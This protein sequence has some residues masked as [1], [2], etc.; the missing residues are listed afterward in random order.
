MLT[1]D[2]AHKRL[3]IVLRTY[4]ALCSFA[5]AADAEDYPVRNCPVPLLNIVAEVP[6]K[7]AAAG[8]EEEPPP[9]GIQL[10]QAGLDYLSGLRPPL[11]MVPALGVYRGGKSMLLNRLQKKTAPYDDGFGVGHQ[12]ETYTRGIQICHEY[13]ADLGTI[14]W[15]DTEG[16]F[17]AEDARGAYGPK[18]FSLALLFSSAVILNNVKVLEDKFFGFFA[19]QQ[20][21]ARM[22]RQGLATEGLPLDAL[23]PTSLSIF[24]VLQQPIH[25]DATGASE[26]L[27][28]Q[29]NTFLDKK[30]DET[31][32]GVKKDFRHCLHQV[33]VATSNQKLWSQ[34]DKVVD[35]ELEPDYLS[36]TAQLREAI[37]GHLKNGTRPMQPASIAK[38]LEMYVDLVRT[39]K[40]SGSLAKEAFEEAQVST[41]CGSFAE[42]AEI[43]AG[44]LPSTSMQAA[45]QSAHAELETERARVA[46]EYHLGASFR[47]RLDACLR[48]RREELQRRNA[49]A[50]LV[51][52]H[53]AAGRLAE[54][55]SC[56]FLD[57]LVKLKKEYQGAFGEAFSRSVQA[58][59]VAIGNNLQ[60]A[61][62]VECV[63][64]REFVWPFYSW[65]LVPVFDFYLRGRS[66]VSGMLTLLSHG[67]VAALIYKSLQGMGQLP[68]YVDLEY[69]VLKHYPVL[70]KIFM[71]APPILPWG[72]IV[73]G[74]F[75]LG[76]LWAAKRI[77]ARW[78][79]PGYGGDYQTAAHL[80][81]VE[82]DV[83]ETRLA[84]ATL[85]RRSEAM[86][87]QQLAGAALDAADALDAGDALA[88]AT[89]LD[90]ALLLAREIPPQDKDLVDRLP[91]G[92][93]MQRRAK[94]LLAGRRSA[95][96]SQTAP[97]SAEG[98]SAER[99]SWPELCRAHGLRVL[100][101][102][103]NWKEL[104][105]RLADIRDALPDNRLDARASQAAAAAGRW[106][107]L[108][109]GR[110]SHASRAEERR[111][112][113]TSGAEDD[114]LAGLGTDEDD[115][116][117][118]VMDAEIYSESELPSA[119]RRS[120]SAGLFGVATLVVLLAAVAVPALRTGAA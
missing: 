46:E 101:G 22:L 79:D 8:K 73:R 53:E 98:G 117:A 33:P 34:L 10:D 36:A 1:M 26:A 2:R 43:A 94:D 76:V 87:R 32:S 17:S 50:V 37:V 64:L 38:Q 105:L 21:L 68:H 12:Q 49:E 114:A 112:D 24:W 9:E 6:D 30:T 20:Q 58:Q 65:A 86:F 107:S 62:L 16:L 100:V 48:S 40:F 82:M 5:A 19:E 29:M 93:N 97:K 80:K 55:G 45:F 92:W 116:G 106:P 102:E 27:T 18:L 77:I 47:K 14:V 66:V 89:A 119:S 104:L 44:V 39:E 81:S 15:M 63:R 41:L 31:R 103:A 84:L 52:W 115:S 59:A 56:F 71:M 7:P 111:Q 99:A 70:L 109:S 61:R 85:L 72:A 67:A 75:G 23:M 120:S 35:E 51:Q 25:Y 113:D 42:R 110:L 28:A 69:P 4:A 57:R 54:S 108:V 11:F 13:V 3:W 91:G 83:A 118:E 78:R 88:A 90:K 96:S 95:S 60:R 74:V